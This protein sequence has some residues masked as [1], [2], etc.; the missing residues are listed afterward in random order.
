MR[1][2]PICIDASLVWEDENSIEIGECNLASR[3]PRVEI[4]ALMDIIVW[5][6]EFD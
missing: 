3:I 4:F 2:R 6:S 1:E 5:Q